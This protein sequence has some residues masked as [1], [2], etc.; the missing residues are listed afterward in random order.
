MKNNKVVYSLILVVA[1][2]IINVVIFLSLQTYSASRILNII[3]LNVAII[4]LWFFIFINLKEAI[5][6]I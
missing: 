1:L 2:L 3:C 6:N 5:I 4:I